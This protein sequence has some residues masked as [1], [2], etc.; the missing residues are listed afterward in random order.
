M[1]V[2]VAPTGES[3]AE[4]AIRKLREE[5]ASGDIEIAHSNADDILCNLLSALGFEDVVAEYAK[6]RKW[7]A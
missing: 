1:E 2:S 7:Y 6:V 4:E 5:Q 3:V